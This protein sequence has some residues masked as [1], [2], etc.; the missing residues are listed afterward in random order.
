MA[1]LINAGETTAANKRIYFHC[2][3]ATDGL[4]PETGEAGGQPQIA[5]NGAAFTNTGIGV[6]VAVGNG[7]YYA[8]LTDGAV[9]TT[10]RVIES[11]YKSAETA[12]ALGTTVQVVAFDPHEITDLGLTNLDAAVSTRSTLAAGAEMDWVDAPNSN[13]VTAIQL[14]LA[15]EATL[16]S[17]VALDSAAATIAAM[18]V[19]LADDNGGADFDAT[20][21]SQKALA[22][23]LGNVVATGAAVN[24]PASGYDLTTGTQTANTYADTA[25]PDGTRH[26]HTDSAGE[27]DLYY[28]FG[29]GG[30][31]VPTSVTI[32]GALTGINDDLEIEAYHWG[33]TDWDR[34]GTIDGAVGSG[35]VAFNF[36]LYTTHV[37]TGDNIGKV[38]IRF[39]DGDYTLTTATLY[40]DQIYVSYAVVTK[41]V[42]YAMGAVW[43]DTVSGVAG[44]ES[45]VN[46][47]ADN[48][49]LTWADALTI[50]AAIGLHTFH[51][52]NGSTIQLSANSD[53]YTI[54]GAEYAIDLN[55]QSCNGM[56]VEEADISGT[57][58]ITGTEMH[59]VRCHVGTCTLGVA[60]LTECVLESVLTIS[61]ADQYVFE[62]CNAGD[63]GGS[64][65]AIDFGAA[66]GSTQI[67]LLGYNGG[68]EIR[69]LGASGTDNFTLKGLG[70]LTIASTCV[71]GTIGIN[72]MI[73]ITDNVVGGFAA[74]GTL[75]DDA[76][77]DIAQI[78]E[79]ADTANTDYGAAVPGDAMALVADAV[80]DTSVEDYSKFKATGFAVAGNQMDLIDA[81]NGT[82]VT[83][84]QL[85][86]ALEATLTAIKGGGWS[87]ETLAAIKAVLDTAAADVENIDGSAMIG[88]NGA[89]LASSW[90]ATL[91]TNL[92]ALVTKFSGITLV[93]NWFAMLAGKAADAPTLAEVQATTAGASFDNTTDSMEALV[94]GGA[95]GLTA[96]QVRNAMGLASTGGTAAD[97]IDDKL[98]DIPADVDTELS[99][100]H[101]DGSWE[102]AGAGTGA[103]PITLTVNDDSG[104]PVS[105]AKIRLQVTGGWAHVVTD[106]SGEADF[107]VDAGSWAAYVGTTASYTPAASYTIVVNALGAI[108]SPTGGILEVTAVSLPV[109]S[110][111][112]NYVIYSQER[113]ADQDDAVFGVGEMTITIIR[114][115][116]NAR[117]DEAAAA[118]R[119]ITGKEYTTDAS[120]N[121]SF[122]IAKEAVAAGGELWL[123]REWTAED[124][125]DDSEQW[126]VTLSADDATEDDQIA[127]ANLAIA[128]V[129]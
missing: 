50:A 37:G 42:G 91:A 67:N 63:S 76:R 127:L 26:T 123:K 90:S 87:D 4:T 35:N 23:A 25:T 47:T 13:A 96:Q 17:P 73:E 52:V 122:E 124:D 92:G 101:G 68:I 2:V 108:T 41:S 55:G 97:S 27:L 30:N 84:I 103:F 118:I 28:E 14:G 5:T 54:M 18:L 34:I 82:A 94:D 78:N 32:L 105:G 38:R 110:D 44:T 95:A 51:I 43:V 80:D 111:P 69:N 93:K 125:S 77:I 70:R 109:P 89:A 59:L 60:H 71:G 45:Y 56:H 7:R 114:M 79:Q 121:W 36:D 46:G 53:N 3:D 75:S 116:L 40:V 58:V 1:L 107:A 62:G 61:A 20:S 100:T 86:L 102:S 129:N 11:R 65:P 22:D 48:P 128:V 120:G 57:A 88:T 72:G 113:Q 126:R 10:G 66:I 117:T 64:P 31:G 15:L 115:E 21:D 104:D 83:A 49:V 81:P 85:G 119:T 8:E 24:T 16:G 29:V 98:D 106:A 19:K 9:D 74:A 112:D 6:L 33:D 12:E 99:S 39:T